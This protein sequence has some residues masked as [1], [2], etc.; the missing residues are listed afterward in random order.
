MDKNDSATMPLVKAAQL[1]RLPYQ[2]AL[3]L[4]LRGELEGSQPDGRH[5]AVTASSVDRVREDR[6][7]AMPAA[8]IA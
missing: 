4:V 8:A 6:E 5:W 1:L 7:S 3:G 2:R